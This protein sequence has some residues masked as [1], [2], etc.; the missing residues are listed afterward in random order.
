MASCCGA[1]DSNQSPVSYQVFPQDKELEHIRTVPE[2][3]TNQLLEQLYQTPDLNLGE[4]T[5]TALKSR[6]SV[7]GKLN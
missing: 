7:P 5:R 1:A 4:N 6:V 3:G 2:A